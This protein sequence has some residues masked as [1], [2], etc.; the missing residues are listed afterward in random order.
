MEAAVKANYTA[1]LDSKKRLTLHGAKHEYY[2]VKE[3]DNG[4]ILLEPRKLVIPEELSPK[5]LQMMDK[6][7]K[8]YKAGTVSEAI[9]LSE[10]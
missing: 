3:Y 4:L 8:N 6:A 7:I 1:H 10:F 9:D 2:N 5:T